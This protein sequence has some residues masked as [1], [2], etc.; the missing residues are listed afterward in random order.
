LEKEAGVIPPFGLSGA[1]PPFVGVDPT[2]AVGASP[3]ATSMSEIA[4]TLA[5]TPERAKLCKG[6]LELR[7]EL[8]ALGLIIGTQWID[9]SFCEDTESLHGRPPG[10]VDVVTLLVRPPPLQ[11]AAAWSVLVAGNLDIF[12]APRAKA[13]YGCEAY[14]IDVGFAAHFIIPQI[15]YWFGLFTHQRVSHMWKGMLQVPLVSDDDVALAHV[16]AVTSSIAILPPVI[17]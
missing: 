14:F 16:D 5:T 10:D 3:Y 17:P 1:L 12:D 2:D 15:T 6:L 9:G 13:K 7:K 11:T 8:R 4:T